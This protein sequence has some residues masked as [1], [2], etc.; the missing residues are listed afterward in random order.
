VELLPLPSLVVGVEGPASVVLRSPDGSTEPFEGP[1]NG[2][3]RGMVIPGGLPGGRN[4]ELDVD[5]LVGRADGP[6]TGSGK[7]GLLKFALELEVG[8]VGVFEGEEDGALM[9]DEPGGPKVSVEFANHGVAL[10]CVKS[11]YLTS[12]FDEE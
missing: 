5:A 9:L 1:P 7:S 6:S 11:K 2:S 10:H 8:A 3:L 4:W 12:E